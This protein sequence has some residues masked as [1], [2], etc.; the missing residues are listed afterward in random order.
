MLD[1]DD[2]RDDELEICYICEEVMNEDGTCPTGCTEADD[3][4][5]GYGVVNGEEE[6]SDGD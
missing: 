6:F 5:F 4:Y 3:Y 2:D 1:T